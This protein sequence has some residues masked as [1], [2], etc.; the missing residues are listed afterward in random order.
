M[1]EQSETRPAWPAWY[2]LAALLGALLLTLIGGG[3]ALAIVAG[4]TGTSIKD[5]GY[6][7]ALTVIQEGFLVATALWLAAKTSHPRP[8]DFGLRPARFWHAVGWVVLGAV[9]Y[10][11]LALAYTAAVHPDEQS[12]LEELGA[13]SGGAIAVLIG[14]MVVA[15]APPIEEFFFRG[16]FYGALRTRFT[17]LAAALMDGVVFGVV[18]AGT[19]PQ[20]IPPLIIFGFVLCLI[21]EATGSILPSICLH[22]LNNMLAF[23][24]D[25]DGSWTVGAL[26]ALAVVTLCVTLPGRLRT[27]T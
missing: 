26:A 8:S 11:A 18:H 23:G 27:L 19:G 13:G 12:T 17:F 7:I 16:F 3:I 14:V 15:V 4:A 5:D 25:K 9:I 1:P 20:A 24:S 21:Y 2:G 10:F 6:N 22:T